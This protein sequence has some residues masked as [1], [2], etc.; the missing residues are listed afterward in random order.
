MRI[1]NISS[2]VAVLLVTLAFGHLLHHH[3]IDASREAIQS[4]AF[5][6]GWAVAVVVGIFS[7][8]GGCLL[9][10]RNR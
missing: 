10:R 5:W 6:A 7:F 4:P 1:L 8:I 9:L 3:F 2:G